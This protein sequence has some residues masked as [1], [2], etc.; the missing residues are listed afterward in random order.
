MLDESYETQRWMSRLIFQSI[1]VHR[2]YK[3]LLEKIVKEREDE[4][5]RIKN[6]YDQQFQ[7]IKEKLQKTNPMYQMVH[8]KRCELKKCQIRCRLLESKIVQNRTN[9]EKKKMAFYEQFVSLA[10][11]W[12]AK[13]DHLRMV[14]EVSDLKKQE[15]EL[16]KK[17]TET[18]ENLKKKQE[19][20]YTRR[21][22]TYFDVSSL[23]LLVHKYS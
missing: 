13:R 3:K 22:S 8:E 2:S 20:A 9:L 11:R 21:D 12:L 14:Q 4:R 16:I 10:R 7:N 23:T 19:T 15:V 5:D 17:V 6:E 18:Q 1:L